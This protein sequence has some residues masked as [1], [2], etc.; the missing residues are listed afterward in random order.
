[1]LNLIK[2]LLLGS[3]NL[4][5]VVEGELQRLKLENPDL[6]EAIDEITA[7]LLSKMDA[8]LTDANI[9]TALDKAVA[10]LLSGDPGE[11]PNAGGL[12]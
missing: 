3:L 10:E 4:R 8:V 2:K 5:A 9:Q 12:A 1:V 7:P 6:E 11:N